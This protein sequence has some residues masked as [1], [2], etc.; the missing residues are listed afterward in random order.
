MAGIDRARDAILLGRQYGSE[1][2][3]QEHGE[4]TTA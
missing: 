4:D 1:Q 3:G 2:A